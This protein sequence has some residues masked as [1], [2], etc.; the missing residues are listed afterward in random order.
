M[1]DELIDQFS[2]LWRIYKSVCKDFENSKWKNSGYGL[3]QPNRL[4]LHII[5]STKFYIE[6]NSPLKYINGKTI[7]MNSWDMDKND[8][9][10][11]DDVLSLVGDIEKKTETW[12]KNINFNSKN[13]KFPWTGKTYGS[14]ILFLLRHSQYHLGEMNCLL[15]DQLEGKAEDY[16]VKENNE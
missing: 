12:L 16:F 9:P 8:L 2:H 15:N 6:D 13:D 11:L 14:I 3:T 5:Q 10:E 4:A 1:R 7:E